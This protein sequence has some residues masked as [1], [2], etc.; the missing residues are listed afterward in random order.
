MVSF[1]SSKGIPAELYA[2]SDQQTCFRFS[3]KLIDRHPH[4]LRVRKLMIYLVTR[5]SMPHKANSSTLSELVLYVGLP[6]GV[7]T[8]V[9]AM[10]Y[11]FLNRIGDK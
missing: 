6:L 10:A 2:I 4:A 11:R 7:A 8:G 9:V 3:T 5:S 1:R